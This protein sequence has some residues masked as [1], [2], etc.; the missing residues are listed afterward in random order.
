[1][2]SAKFTLERIKELAYK[3][4][5]V[6]FLD[7]DGTS[8]EAQQDSTYSYDE[9]RGILKIV[10]PDLE[11][12]DKSLLLEIIRKVKE[13]G[14]LGFKDSKKEIL[15]SYI[16]YVSNNS[17]KNILQFYSDI[18]TKDDYGALKMS[19]YLRYEA[20]KGNNI[21]IYKKDIRNKFGTR[22]V[23]I[24]NL[25]SAGYF[26]T[27]FR[28]LYNTEE[29]KEFRRYYEIAVGM[30]A[31]ALFV[32]SH[33]N[34]PAIEQSFEVML[35]KALRYHMKE[36]RIH[37]KGKINVINIKK[38]VSERKITAEDVYTIKKVYDDL[39]L[40]AIEYIVEISE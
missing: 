15:N 2:S 6:I 18:L 35:D 37:G 32:N 12:R 7:V 11:I 8:Q 16:E 19:L 31:R 30:G 22:G 40:F 24:S 3:K 25:C 20:K 1:M 27:E 13:D 39:D 5:V 14:G 4:G 21:F 17:D 28:E 29:E 36:F 26:E 34:V 9:K 33:M 23:N 38:F 10:V